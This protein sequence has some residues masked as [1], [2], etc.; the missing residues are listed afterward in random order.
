MHA[1]P[2]PLRT[3]SIGGAAYDLFISTNRTVTQSPDGHEAFVLPLG[4][5]IW[6]TEVFGRC[7]GGASNTSVGLSRLGCEAHFCGMLGDDQWGEQILRNLQDENVFTEAATIIEHE[8]SN[9]S[10]ILSA[11]SG[12]RVILGHAAM[13]KHLHDVTFDRERA[14]SV[15]WVYLNHIHADSCAIEDDVIA[16]LTGSNHKRITWNPG[17][18]QIDAGIRVKNNQTLVANTDLLLLNKEEAHAFTGKEQLEHGLR[19]LKEIGAGVVCVTDG[20][21]GAYATDGKGIFFCPAPECAVVDTTGAGDAFGTAMTWALGT[22]KDLPTALKAGTINAM[23]VVGAVGSQP[24][25]L[26]ETEIKARITSAK[27]DITIAP[28]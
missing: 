7:G 22:G 12:E 2:S 10:V 21:R 20:K 11:T 13:S 17:G 26:T 18:C 16:I 25:L 8:P 19:I 3:I 14:G 23:S 1:T 6:I 27:I 4:E 15:D 28:L 5:K 9:F 24:G